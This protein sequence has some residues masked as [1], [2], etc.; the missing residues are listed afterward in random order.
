MRP[1]CVYFYCAKW[2]KIFYL[3]PLHPCKYA[4]ICLYSSFGCTSVYFIWYLTVR[5]ELILEQEELVWGIC[6]RCLYSVC[7]LSMTNGETEQII[8]FFNK[9]NFRF[10][11]FLRT[12]MRRLFVALW[13]VYHPTLNIIVAFCISFDSIQIFPK[14]IISIHSFF[15]C[16]FTINLFNFTNLLFI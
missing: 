4:L 12:D 3:F 15:F 13:L 7:L 9:K 8:S 5:W 16:P 14:L 11:S 6:F 10:F 2:M 1:L